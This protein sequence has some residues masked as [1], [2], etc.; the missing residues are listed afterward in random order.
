MDEADDP[1][2]DLCDPSDGTE[3]YP[4]P[5]CCGCGATGAGDAPDCICE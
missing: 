2:C 5:H 4:Y 1:Y 3:P